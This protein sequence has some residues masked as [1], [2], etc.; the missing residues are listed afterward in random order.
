MKKYLFQI[1]N[2]HV[3]QNQI[4]F[5]KIHSW[6]QNS[7]QRCSS[8]FKPTWQNRVIYMPQRIGI[9]N[10]RCYR[11]RKHI[12]IIKAKPLPSIHSIDKNYF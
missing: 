1:I 5:G 12:F 11:V 10:S 9:G 3:C 2:L 8:F 4:P 6:I 7:K